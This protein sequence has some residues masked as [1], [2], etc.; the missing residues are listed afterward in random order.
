MCHLDDDGVCESFIAAIRDHTHALLGIT[1]GLERA[2]WSEPSRLP[3]WTRAH[4]AAHLAAGARAMLQASAP[5]TTSSTV[6]LYSSERDKLFDIE[7]NSIAT[8]LELQIALDE[9]AGYL[10]SAWSACDVGRHHVELRPGLRICARDLPLVRLQEVV[11]HTYDMRLELTVPQ[12]PVTVA[13][14][15]LRF[16]AAQVEGRPDIPALELHTEDGSTVTVS[17]DG[18]P[19]HISGSATDLLLWLARG[20]QSAQLD[21]G[22]DLYRDPYQFH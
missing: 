14:Y 22:F 17:G 16:Y 8:G 21:G 13:S 6:R 18:E 5:E 10:D 11:L 12:L 9:T 19:R 15:A 1:I 20:Y 7:R 3:Q 2:D 4:V